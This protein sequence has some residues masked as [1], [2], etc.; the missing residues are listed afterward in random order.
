MD[1]EMPDSCGNHYAQILEA[2]Q[3]GKLP[4]ETLETAIKRI[5]RVNTDYAGNIL[6]EKRRKEVLAETRERHHDLAKRIEEE[7]A[8]LLK[9]EEF[10]PLSKEIKEILIIGDMASTPRIQGGG[11]SHIHTERVISFVEAFEKR[12]IKVCYAKGYKNSTFHRSHRLEKE[13]CKKVEDAK[14]RQIPVLFFGGLTEMAEGEGYDRE[15]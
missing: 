4:Q 1:V 14:K 13:A 15:S 8:V 12:D 10:L 6:P 9:N 5:E 3:S 11:S 7:S 2:I